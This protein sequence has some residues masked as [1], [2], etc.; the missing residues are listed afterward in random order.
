MSMQQPPQ[1]KSFTSS[2]NGISRVLLSPVW[3]ASAFNPLTVP[4]ATPEKLG[5]KNYMA[6]WDTG[7]TSCVV[8]EK[9]I[10]ECNLK[11]ISV[12]KVNTADGEHDAFV[13]LI[14]L[15]LPNRFIL[16]QLVAVSGRLKGGDMLIGM[17]VINRGDFAVTNVGRKTIMT[18]RLPSCECI[19]FVEEEKAKGG[20][21]GREVIQ[22]GK[23]PGKVGRNDPCPCGSGKKYKKCCGK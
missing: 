16:P 5:A 11:P 10:N 8:N 12:T 18:F 3:V 1:R 22:L 17:D 7:A 19:D 13:Y 20:K 9:V 21:E 23:S 15:F 2:F 14:S 6:I 4:N